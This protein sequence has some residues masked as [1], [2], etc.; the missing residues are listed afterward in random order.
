MPHLVITRKNRNHFRIR[1]ASSSSFRVPQQHY[2]KAEK[3]A[4]AER[5]QIALI[6]AYLEVADEKQAHP[7]DAEDDRDQI[8]QVK[9]FADEKRSKYKDINRSGILEK[10]RVGGGCVFCGPDE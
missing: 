5:R 7:A 1:F 8:F 3:D 6:V 4:G 9:F 10:Y 2:V